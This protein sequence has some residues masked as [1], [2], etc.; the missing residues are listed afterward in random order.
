VEIL[1]G[2]L[3]KAKN[4]FALAM[5]SIK[6]NPLEIKKKG[7]DAKVKNILKDF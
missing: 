2:W 4:L 3:S 6:K 1:D 5:E 7:S